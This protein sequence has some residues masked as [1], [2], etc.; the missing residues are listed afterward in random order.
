MN[1]EI[2]RILRLLE[3]GEIDAEQA[4]R[5]IRAIGAKPVH[6]KMPGPEWPRLS[7]GGG[8]GVMRGLGRAM[9]QVD[10]AFQS[11]FESCGPS[12]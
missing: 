6:L 1:E 2:S 10:K 4:D 5:L 12:G 11:L 8:I 9:K 7:F 3:K